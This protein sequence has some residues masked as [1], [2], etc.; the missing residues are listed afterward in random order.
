M[1]LVVTD[2]SSCS[3]PSAIIRFGL[4][5]HLYLVTR[6]LANIP[7]KYNL[8]STSH[9]EHCHMTWPPAADCENICPFLL[10]WK[11]QKVHRRWNE[12]E[13]IRKGLK[14]KGN[15]DCINWWRLFVVYIKKIKIR[16]V[17]LQGSCLLQ[18]YFR[19][20]FMSLLFARLLNSV[21]SVKWSKFTYFNQQLFMSWL[22]LL[23]Y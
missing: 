16:E 15:R 5:L 6:H 22:F 10:Q 18:W 1:G 11:H 20:I 9:K 21:T 8:N 4:L 12:G 2:S 19:S 14:V 3:I 7:E 23:T 17:S 13:G